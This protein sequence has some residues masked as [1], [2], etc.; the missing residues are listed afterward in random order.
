M[1]WLALT[2]FGIAW[3]WAA[4]RSGL[5]KSFF[6]AAHETAALFWSIRVLVLGSLLAFSA[7]LLW[8]AVFSPWVWPHGVWVHAAGLLLSLAGAALFAWVSWALGKHFS[9][10]L[11]LRDDHR[12]V[13]EGPYRWV[14]HPMYLAYQLAWFGF[15]LATGNVLAGVAGIL[16][17]ALAMWV[18]VGA[19]EAMLAARFG[20]QWQEYCQ[21]TGRFLPRIIHTVSK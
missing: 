3:V 12:L 2:V 20:E 16:A 5:Q 15:W 21:R 18:R 19:E 4:W 6:R 11:H 10:S 8:P 9:T 17:F 7:G 13:T 14:R 1:G